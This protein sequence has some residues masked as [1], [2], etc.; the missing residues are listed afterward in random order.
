MHTYM[1][2]TCLDTHIEAYTLSHTHILIHIHN[3]KT[4]AFNSCLHQH[5]MKLE[6]NTVFK[7]ETTK[8]MCTNLT[9]TVKRSPQGNIW[10]YFAGHLIR[11]LHRH[12]KCHR[13]VYTIYSTFSE[14]H[15]CTLDAY[16][17]VNSNTVQEKK[18]QM[19]K[20]QIF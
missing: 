6:Y 19:L 17:S 1:P 16:A 10:F 11:Y 4:H 12:Q 15:A 7:G 2:H 14:K 13:L 18:L 3:T 8:N 20:F 9:S 5:K